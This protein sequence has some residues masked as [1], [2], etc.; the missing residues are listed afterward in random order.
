MSDGA[1]EGLFRRNDD[2]VENEREGRSIRGGVIP[3]RPR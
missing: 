3:R 2:G 1:R